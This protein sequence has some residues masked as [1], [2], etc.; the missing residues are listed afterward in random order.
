MNERVVSLEAAIEWLCEGAGP[1]GSETLPLEQCG[2]RVAATDIKAPLDMPPWPAA[3]VDGYAVVWHQ[4]QRHYE[5]IGT[6]EAGAPPP[7]RFAEGQALRVFTGAELPV[8]SSV[9]IRDED[10]EWENGELLVRAMPRVRYIAPVGSR[11]RQ[12]AVLAPSGAVLGIESLELLSS[13]GIADLSVYRKP[14]VGV[15]VSGSELQ[16][17]GQELGPGQIYNSNRIMYSRMLCAAGAEPVLLPAWTVP[18]CEE[19]LIAAID[20]LR[21]DCGVIILC[22]GSGRGGKDLSKAVLERMGA[23]FLFTGVDVKPGNSSSAARLGSCTIINLPGPPA[24]G[25]LLFYT[26]VLPMLRRLRGVKDIDDDWFEVALLRAE[27]PQPM[28]SLRMLSLLSAKGQF[29]VGS[30]VRS[31][32]VCL[33]EV[34]VDVPPEG[35]KAGAIVNARLI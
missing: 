2:E 1:D 15:L 17:P 29:W 31:D 23:E 13:L 33:G 24:A 6:L 20:E 11:V 27:H 12:G 4:W 30:N 16:T 21:A 7:E 8:S 35:G 18:D 5:V 32:A 26:L 22:G 3:K 34:V 25:R 19:D 9:V 28:R 14:R 10:A